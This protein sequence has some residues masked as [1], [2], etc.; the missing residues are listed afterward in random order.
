MDDDAVDG[1]DVLVGLFEGA[2]VD[3]CASEAEGW[4]VAVDD[5]ADGFVFA[6][7]GED[8]SWCGG[9]VAS[10]VELAEGF[11]FGYCALGDVGFVC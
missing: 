2:F 8:F 5:G 1:A 9:V 6:F 10:V 11:V 7:E 4:W 3:V